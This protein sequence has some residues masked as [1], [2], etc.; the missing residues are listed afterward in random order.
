MSE[1][2]LLRGAFPVRLLSDYAVCLGLRCGST[3][4]AWK[5]TCTKGVCFFLPRL[6]PNHT[7]YFDNSQSILI[8]VLEDQDCSL[9]KKFAKI[10]AHKQTKYCKQFALFKKIAKIFAHKQNNLQKM[11]IDRL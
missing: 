10:F 11:C 3:P 5:K 1:Y 2:C 6:N 8:D 7:A 4:S 9:F